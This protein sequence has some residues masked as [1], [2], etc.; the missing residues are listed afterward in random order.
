M[1]L[2]KTYVNWMD[3]LPLILKII[4]ALPVLDI[5]WGLYRIFDGVTRSNIVNIILGILWIIPGATI[6][7][8]LDIVFLVISGRVLKS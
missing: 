2:L 8:I 4:F 5:L 7:W 3:D 6:C 1:D